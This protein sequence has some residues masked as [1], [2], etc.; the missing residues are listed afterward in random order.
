MSARSAE[1]Q[2]DTLSGHTPLSPCPVV[3]VLKDDR[4]GN[5][6]QSLGLAD[7]LGWPYV[8]KDLRFSR[9]AYLHKIHERLLSATT[10]CLDQESSSALVPPWPDVVIS[11]GRRAAPI[12]RWIR[13]Q[14]REKTKLVQLGRKGSQSAH[15]FDVSIAPIFCRMWPND[16]RIETIAPLNRVTTQQLAA[17][18]QEWKD[19]FKED[20]HPHV[21]LLVG[22]STVRCELDQLVAGQVGRDVA[23]FVEKM[24][25]TLHVVTSRRTG[26]QATDA[27]TEAIG[28]AGLVRRWKPSQQHNPYWGY[29]AVAD[30]I[31]VTG[32]S[33]SMVGES[34]S[35]GKPVYIYSLPQKPLSV[36]SRIREWIVVTGR[37]KLNSRKGGTAWNQSI[38]ALCALVLRHGLV[39]PLR[40]LNAFHQNLIDQG[41][42]FPFGREV[43][44]KSPVPLRETEVVSQKVKSLLGFQES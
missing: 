37:A 9:L 26:I 1:N 16:R 42:A 22:G 39:R 28:D 5:S 32:D 8:T 4:P 17:A 31:I 24:G 2:A 12:A 3:W 18:A 40:D 15:Q 35:T 23:A 38:K 20:P 14:S 7:A 25:A 13:Q 27:L 36:F 21:V 41:Y 33:E 44:K 43:P 6:T 34:V 10:I 29:L 19:L 30:I 11:A